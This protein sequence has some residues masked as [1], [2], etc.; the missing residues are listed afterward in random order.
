MKNT[1]VFLLSVLLLLLLAPGGFIG[2]APTLQDTS[3]NKT[4]DQKPEYFNI[5]S[6]NRIYDLINATIYVRPQENKPMMI[7]LEVNGKDSN[8][9]INAEFS[10]EKDCFKGNTKWWELFVKV[11][12]MNHTIDNQNIIK[13]KYKLQVRTSSCIK[14]CIKEVHMQG[15]ETLH[16]KASSYSN[17]ILQRPVNDEFL[18]WNTT[19]Y[20]D[21]FPQCCDYKKPSSP[22]S[23]AIP[24]SATLTPTSGKSTT[25]SVTSSPDFIGG[26]AGGVAGIIAMVLVVVL[27]K[28]RGKT[29]VPMRPK[30]T[31]S[32]REGSVN[33]LY[34]PVGR[35]DPVNGNTDKQG[36]VN[37]LYEA[38]GRREPVNDLYEPAGRQ[39]PVYETIHKG[40]YV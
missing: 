25:L 20:D 28:R 3:C 15:L 13:S 29:N 38:I 39:E 34:E 27:W 4:L 16:V 24:T 31:E 21:V 37:S 32:P 1:L 9:T 7:L 14:P 2:P 26:I 36:S 23:A 12:L 35:Q 19:S 33:S 40:G 5:T 30:K 8:I 22:S 18:N 6:A 17:Y 11:K 10:L